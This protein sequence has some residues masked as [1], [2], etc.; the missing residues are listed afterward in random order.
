M[1]SRRCNIQREF[2]ILDWIINS[3]SDSKGTLLWLCRWKTNHH[4]L[5]W[6]GL[7]NKTC[8]SRIKAGKS[9]FLVH[10]ERTE[11]KHFLTCMH[12][13]QDTTSRLLIPL[14]QHHENIFVYQ[15]DTYQFVIAFRETTPLAQLCPPKVHNP[16]LN[17]QF[18]EITS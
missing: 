3:H 14:K 1:P 13:I 2:L 5:V 8:I 9:M 12:L 18:V 4:D 15:V 11:K 7:P 6:L 17:S 10:P 16:A